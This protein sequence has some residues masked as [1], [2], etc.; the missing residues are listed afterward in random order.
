MAKRKALPAIPATPTTRS[1]KVDLGASTY[2]EEPF[3]KGRKSSATAAPKDALVAA[4]VVIVAPVESDEVELDEETEETYVPITTHEDAMITARNLSIDLAYLLRKQ[5]KSKLLMEYK[6]LVEYLSNSEFYKTAD[7]YDDC[8]KYDNYLKVLGQKRVDDMNSQK[9]KPRLGERRRW[10][11]TE[12]VFALCVAC[13]KAGR[14]PQRCIFLNKGGVVNHRRV[15]LQSASASALEK[16]K[17]PAVSL[18][19]NLEVI[20]HK[21]TTQGHLRVNRKAEFT[22]EDGILFKLPNLVNIN[23]HYLIEAVPKL[24]GERGVEWKL[25]GEQVRQV[26]T[27]INLLRWMRDLVNGTVPSGY[28]HVQG[29]PEPVALVKEEDAKEGDGNASGDG[30]VLA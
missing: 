16:C 30:G 22:E 9:Y 11:L 28:V 18:E 26:G 27:R 10:I 21:N 29:Q 1:K 6:S 14:I 23:C 2:G 4:P 13:F 5:P 8:W 15:K 3:K 12:Q 20:T 17:N 25:V 7:D 19:G 24:T